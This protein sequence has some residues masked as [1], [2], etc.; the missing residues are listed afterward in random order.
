MFTLEQLKAAH[1]K[2]KS[3]ADFPRYIQEIKA[4]GLIT[5]VYNLADGST[6]YYGANGHQVS[7]PAIYPPKTIN[8]EALAD[9]LRYTIAIHQQGQTDFLT[10]CTQA[11]AS[12]VKQW[13]I[14]TVQMACIYQDVNGNNMVIEPI[15]EEDYI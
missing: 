3:G 7:A 8:S 1:A 5:Y 15:P 14:D 4:L 10:F 11:A 13:V 9:Q 6:T 12:G 2:V